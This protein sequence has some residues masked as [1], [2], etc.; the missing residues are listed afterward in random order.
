MSE[1]ALSIGAYCVASGAYVI[2]GGSS[3]VSGMPDRVADSDII[4]HYLSEGWEKL[5]GGK[6]EFI[7][8]PKEMVRKTLEHIDQKRAELGLP[9]YDPTHFGRSGDARMVELEKLPLAERQAALY[10]VA[11]D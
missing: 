5:Y 11:A 1:K 9:D 6:L 8:D 3:P 2:F 4:L 7:P 10:G